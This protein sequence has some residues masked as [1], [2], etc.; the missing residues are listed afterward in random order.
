MDNKF[1]SARFIFVTGIGGADLASKAVWNAM[2]MHK[3]NVAKRIFFLESPDNREYE[4]IREITNNKINGL[5]EIALIAVS[6]SG[7]TRETLESFR[8]TFNIL[9]EKFGELVTKRTL[10]ISTED[11]PLWDLAEEKN[12][13]RR[14]WEGMIGGRFSAFTVA[15]TTVLEIAGLDVEAFK[16]GQKI[17]DEKC[18]FE[19]LDN[20]A[21][22]LAQNIF[23][24]YKKDFDILNFF[25]FN[26]ELEDLGKWCRQ[27]V[28]E[29]LASITPTVSVG[30]ADLHSM[31]ELY[32]GGPKNRFTIFI[33]SAREIQNNI[34]NTAYDEVT[35]SYR[36][37]GLPFIKYEME[38]INEQE[39]G[40]FMEFMIKTIIEL[41]N[42]L[43][44]DPY[45]QPAVDNYKKSLHNS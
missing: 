14:A 39:I 19:D 34:N 16:K 29:S 6:K 11:S 32:L 26:T 31:L 37:E 20:P 13:D 9:S 17:M 24:Y 40:S 35:R 4:E 8:K 38:E 5:E 7:K 25:T 45:D 3:P 42:L 22:H 18:S 30:P 1:Q 44:V 12:I 15:H 2:T 41:A 27:L 33:K 23:E 43:E 36:E 28:A 10:V 21:K